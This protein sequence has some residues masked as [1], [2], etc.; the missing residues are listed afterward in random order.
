MDVEYSSGGAEATVHLRMAGAW[1]P[2]DE[3]RHQLR[4]PLAIAA[5]RAR[6]WTAGA[7][8]EVAATLVDLSSRGVGLSL[9]HEVQPGDRLSLA[10]PIGGGQADLRVTVEVRHVRD[11][12]DGPQRWRA[13]GP[14]RN[15]APG[16]H[17]RVIRFIF[18][19]LRARRG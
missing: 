4:V 5:S 3:R 6:R 11:A 18:A 15:L 17:E 7:W 2:E 14:F 10:V 13:G 9:D 12:G 16:D 8:R 1:Q 19:E